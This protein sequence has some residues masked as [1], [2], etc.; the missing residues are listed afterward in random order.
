[1]LL[2]HPRGQAGGWQL[3][4]RVYGG[5]LHTQVEPLSEDLN[6]LSFS[7]LPVPPTLQQPQARESLANE[8]PKTLQCDK[9]GGGRWAGERMD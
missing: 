4:P 5:S 8:E 7:Y 2:P 1:M 3:L 9:G 6:L